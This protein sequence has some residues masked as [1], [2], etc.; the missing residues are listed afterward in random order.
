MAG[1]MLQLGFFQFKL[2]TAAYQ[3]LSRS[4]DYKWVRV[5]RIGSTDAMQFTGYGADGIDLEGVVFPNF[6]GGFGQLDKLRRQASLGVPLPAVAGTGKFLGL[7]CVE[8]VSEGQETFW[9]DGS[10]RRQD[11]NLRISKY[12]GGIRSILPF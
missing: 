2:D 7:W 6:M 12:G 1:V 3:R 9:R 10:P 11:F 5:P 8:N 4:T